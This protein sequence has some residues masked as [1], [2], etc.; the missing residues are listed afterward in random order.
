[1]QRVAA[2][3]IHLERATER[4]AQVARL[5]EAL[6]VPAEVLPAVDARAEKGGLE[7]HYDRCLG[8]QPRYPFPLSDT[9]IAVFL[10]HRKAWARIVE[11]GHEAGLVLED[12]IWLDPE[13]FP[14]GLH[15]AM[16]ALGERRWIRFPQFDKEAEGELVAEAGG[17]RLVRPRRVALGMLVQLVHRSAAERL[18]RLTERF[19]RPVDGVLQLTWETGID[20][21]AVLPAAVREIS[22]ELGG[23]T[24]K[25]RNGVGARLHAEL[26]RALYRRR[27]AARLRRG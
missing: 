7:R 10:S 15:L 11:D 6:P 1:M 25:K 22:A 2:Y 5:I 14:A 4:A 20:T 27:L 18:L 17:M 16:Q 9:E 8:W 3:I 12:D 21:L 13:R 23:S 26:A 24:L 19:D